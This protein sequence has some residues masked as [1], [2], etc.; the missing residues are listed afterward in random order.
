MARISIHT[1]NGNGERYDVWS[2]N[3]KTTGVEHWN[4]F[5]RRWSR[6]VPDGQTLAEFAPDVASRIG[7]TWAVRLQTAIDISLSMKVEELALRVAS[8]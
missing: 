7:P 4:G 5:Q 1:D 2:M 8:A 6:F 3:D